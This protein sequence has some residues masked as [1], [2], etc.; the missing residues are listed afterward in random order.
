MKKDYPNI[1]KPLRI[2]GKTLKNRIEAAPI[3]VFD[4][5]TTPERHPSERD[6]QFFR[7]QAMGGPAIV[8][9][10]DCIVDPTGEDS[11]LLGS[12]KIMAANVDNLPFLTRIADEIHRYGALASIELNH[13]GMLLSLIHI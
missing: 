7:M 12:P 11:G 6:M 13:A 5:D 9:L 2:R 4:L 1:F 10:G 8:T 3:S